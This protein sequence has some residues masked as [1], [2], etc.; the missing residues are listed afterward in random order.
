MATFDYRFELAAPLAAVRDFH[1]DTRV[2]KRLTPPPIFV[3]VHLFEPLAEGAVADLTMWFGPVPV[4]WQVTHHD[5]DGH[6]FTDEQTEGPLASWRHTHRFVPV[7]P[8]RTQVHEHI[9]YRHRSGWQGVLTRLP[10]N[11]VALFFLFT[12]RRLVTAWALRDQ[13]PSRAPQPRLVGAAAAL[14]GFAAWLL[15]R[16][17]RNAAPTDRE[18]DDG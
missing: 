11:H 8:G 16:Q 7:A 14:L 6:G 3:Q 13:A 17:R 1:H 18:H 10:F 12:Y 2:L 9:E 5:V 4:R 15:I